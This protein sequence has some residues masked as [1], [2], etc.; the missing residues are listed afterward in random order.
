[1]IRWLLSALILLLPTSLLGV[2]IVQGG[3]AAPVTCITDSAADDFS[4]GSIGTTWDEAGNETNINCPWSIGSGV[5]TWDSN[6]NSQCDNDTL[7]ALAAD[8]VGG[9]DQWACITWVSFSTQT[10]DPGL[11]FR[12]SSITESTN[13]VQVYSD[14]ALEVESG[15]IRWNEGPGEPADIDTCTLS[16][17]VTFSPG[18]RL[19]AQISGAGAS[20]TVE[21]WVNPTGSG[22]DNFSGD[23]CTM[24]GT[25]TKD[26]GNFIGVHGDGGPTNTGGQLVFDDKVGGSCS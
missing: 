4:T 10:K 8:T 24:S 5:L 20:T 26:T 22:P 12:G 16:G 1:M 14:F 21:V 7:L 19:C 9:A 2:V 13:W 15:L 23:G 25:G 11:T 6:H 3:G 17:S 18:D